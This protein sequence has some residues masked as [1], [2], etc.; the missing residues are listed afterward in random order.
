MVGQPLARRKFAAHDSKNSST[1]VRLLSGTRYGHIGP[2]ISR[3]RR[4]S[5]EAARSRAE[6]G[7]T[8]HR[9]SPRRRREPRGFGVV[10]AAARLESEA[11]AA[12]LIL[13]RR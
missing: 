7:E 12:L 2:T 1:A 13:D 6:E 4:T 5:A 10:S 9:R 3:E 11:A 8:E